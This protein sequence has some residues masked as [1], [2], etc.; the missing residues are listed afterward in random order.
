[1]QRLCSIFHEKRIE[2][3]TKVDG[4]S[5]SDIIVLFKVTKIVEGRTK[6]SN[7]FVKDQEDKGEERVKDNI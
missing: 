5:N 3:F 4:R 2:M 7:I 6:S 1:M